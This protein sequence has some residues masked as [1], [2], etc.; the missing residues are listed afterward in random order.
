MRSPALLHPRA[1]PCSASPVPLLSHSR[2]GVVRLCVGL[3]RGGL[4]LLFANQKELNISLPAP[5]AGTALSIR[6]VLI[7]LKVRSSGLPLGPA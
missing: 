7:H 2:A 4:E 1:S 5:R 6:D 3:H